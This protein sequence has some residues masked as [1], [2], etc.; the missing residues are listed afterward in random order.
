MRLQQEDNNQCI[1]LHMFFKAQQQ[2]QQQQQQQMRVRPN[3][4][5]KCTLKRRSKSLGHLY[6]KDYF[7]FSSTFRRNIDRLSLHVAYCMSILGLVCK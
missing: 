2:Q 6:G 3:G 7:G 5:R 4:G 1:P